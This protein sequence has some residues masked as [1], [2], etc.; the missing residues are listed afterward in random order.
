MPT[1]TEQSRIAKAKFAI[2]DARELLVMVFAAHHSGDCVQSPDTL[3]DA[4]KALA[5]LNEA[6][7]I[8][9]EME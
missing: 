8:V 9:E 3:I 1:T 4:D 7:F 5:H 6:A 2:R